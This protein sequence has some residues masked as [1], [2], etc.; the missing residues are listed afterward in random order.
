MRV[1]IVWRDGQE[2]SRMVSDWLVDFERRTGKVIESLDPD[3]IEGDQFVRSYDIVE[4][5]TMIALGDDGRVLES[6]IGRRLPRFDE[7]SYYAPGR[8]TE[9]DK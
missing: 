3:S 2:Y 7:V 9:G 1:V 5:P 6:W 4:F 8:F